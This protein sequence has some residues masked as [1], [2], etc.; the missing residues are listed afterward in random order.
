MDLELGKNGEDSLAYEVKDE[1][2]LVSTTCNSDLK[3][4]LSNFHD[5]HVRVVDARSVLNI[6]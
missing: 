6:A 2:R 5:T 1:S 4:D 3:D